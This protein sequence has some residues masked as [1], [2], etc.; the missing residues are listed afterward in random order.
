MVLEDFQSSMLTDHFDGALEC[1]II[2]PKKNGK[3][4]LLAALALFH[5]VVTPDAECVVGAA[6]RDQATI[7]YDQA[8]GFVRRCPA[9]AERVDVKRGYREIRSRRDSGRIRVLAAD[10]DTADGVIPTLALVDELH[11]HKSAGLYGIFR[12]G[13]GPRSGQMITISTAGEHEVSPLGT[14]RLAALALPEQEREGSHLRCTSEDGAY[15][16]HEWALGRDDDR[17]DMTVVKTANPASWQTVAALK[18]RHDSP[19]MLDWQWARFACGVW[20]AAEE[21]WISGEDWAHLR[22]HERL[23][24][25]DMITVGFDGARTGDATALVGCRVS[26]GL[27]QLLD[28]WEAPT[29][30]RAWEVPTEVVDVA[31]SNAME[32]YR[33]VRGYF[34]PPLWRTEIEGWA[35]EFGDTAVRKFD[36]TKV[37]MVGA[38]ERFRTDVTARTL[39]VSVNEVLTRHVLNA[40]VKEARGGGY[41][42]G[43]DRAGS[44]NRID[45]AIA[46]VL[47]YEARADALAAGEA[48]PRSRVPTSW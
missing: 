11:R 24:D 34:D 48:T 40:Q 21:W 10:V 26:D 44:V 15:V 39:K 43:K 45:A 20:V 5:L 25:G 27:I 41:W 47:A 2:I 31:L 23:T 3:S 1:L 18:S 22:T 46:A 12:D 29:D 38:V 19:S 30:G 9:L 28:V 4:T 36:T 17:D 42:L 8:A 13:L 37:R 6:S 7:L 14:M 16:M 35:R 32:R 33:V